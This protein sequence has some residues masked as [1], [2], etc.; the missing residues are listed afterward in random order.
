M[1]VA[2]MC[3]A[4]LRLPAALIFVLP[5]Y[6]L[7]VFAALALTDP[8]VRTAGVLLSAAIAAIL[9]GASGS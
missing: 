5:V 4:W 8:C 6:A 1:E 7:H 9:G 2:V 3:S